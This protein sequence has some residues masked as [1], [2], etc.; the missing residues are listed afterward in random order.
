MTQ[1]QDR[2]ASHPYWRFMAMIAA[3]TVVMFGMMYLNTYALDHVFWSETRF[4]MTFV[5][6]AAMMVV[7]L[8][9][10]W[11]MYPSRARNFVILAVA[12]LV[13]ALAFA[14]VLLWSAWQARAVAKTEAKLSANQT[15]AVL[16]SGQDAVATVG[17]THAAE[18]RI[19]VVTREN[20]RAIRQAP[21]ADAPVD[22][23]LDAA[24]RRGLC[25]YAA[26]RRQPECLQ[27]PAAE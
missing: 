9:F 18:V 21:G 5:M 19:D 13:F 26:Y 27:Q 16:E 12:A 23:A 14:G 4:W 25:R 2:S 22:P 7:M 17:Q 3:G 6:G 11:D 20:E 8:A 15:E 24:A 1:Q 10:M